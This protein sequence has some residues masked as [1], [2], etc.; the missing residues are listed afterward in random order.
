MAAA[1]DPMFCCHRITRSH[2]VG[3]KD[4]APA[5]QP[6]A[7]YAKLTHAIARLLAAGQCFHPRVKHDTNPSGKSLSEKSVLPY[8]SVRQYTA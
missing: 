2:L 6:T 5:A 8:V 1:A 4:A 3:Y 7:R